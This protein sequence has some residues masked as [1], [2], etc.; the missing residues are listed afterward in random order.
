MHYYANRIIV[1]IGW[2]VNDE[3][4]FTGKKRFKLPFII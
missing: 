3:Q 2:T 4:L 1:Y